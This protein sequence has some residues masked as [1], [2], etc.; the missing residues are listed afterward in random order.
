MRPRT[1]GRKTVGVTRR[2]H[3]IFAQEDPASRPPRTCDKAS[4]I[5]SIGGAACDA[6]MRWENDFGI[7]R[8]LENGTAGFKAGRAFLRR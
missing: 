5:R 4:I 1:S 2:N 8:G 3:M 6:A 7:D